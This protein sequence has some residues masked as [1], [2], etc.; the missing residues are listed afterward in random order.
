MLTADISNN[1]SSISNNSVSSAESCACSNA[2]AQAMTSVCINSR[3]HAMRHSRPSAMKKPEL[4]PLEDARAILSRL[5][6]PGITGT[7]LSLLNRRLEKCGVGYE[8]LDA[9][10]LKSNA[11]MLVLVN[12]RARAG[13]MGE[14]KT[15]VSEITTH[16]YPEVILS[17]LSSTFKQLDEMPDAGKSEK[18]ALHAYKMKAARKIKAVAK[19]GS[20]P[21]EQ[22][23]IFKQAKN[24]VAAMS[25]SGLKGSKLSRQANKVYRRAFKASAHAL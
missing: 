23:H 14:V 11:E 3:H 15:L 9:S 20:A 18:Q 12:E 17:L 25:R 16:R 10:G 6:T 8:A 22:V 13:Y 5:G 24:E 19:S 7:L 2:E 4:T 21:Q 1:H